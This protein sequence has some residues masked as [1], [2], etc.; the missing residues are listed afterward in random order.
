MNPENFSPNMQGFENQVINEEYKIWKKYAPFYYD[1]MI[2]HL[3]EWPS[4]TVEWLPIHES[5]EDSNFKIVKMLLGTFTGN[6]EPNY[7]LVAKVAQDL[8]LVE[9]SKGQCAHQ[10]RRIQLF[11]SEETRYSSHWTIKWFF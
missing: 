11:P 2:T 1:L 9:N 10:F 4:L 6:T 5:S 7:L 8:T 3:L